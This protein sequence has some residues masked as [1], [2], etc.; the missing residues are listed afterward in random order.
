[1]LQF[2]PLVFL[3]HKL[4]I[5]YRTCNHKNQTLGKGFKFRKVKSQEGLEVHLQGWAGH[6]QLEAVDDVWVEDPETPHALPRDKDLS[7]ATGE[8]GGI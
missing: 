3:M 6:G 7:T 8:E 4:E 2:G 1:M 5:I